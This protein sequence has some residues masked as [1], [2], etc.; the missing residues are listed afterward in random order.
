MSQFGVLSSFDHN[1][2]CWQVYRDRLQQWFIAND[3][4]ETKDATGVKRRAILLSALSESTYLANTLLPCYAHTGNTRFISKTCGFGERYKFS[5]ATQFQ[6]ERMTAHCG[7][8]NVEEALRDHFVMGMLPGAER[9]KLFAQDPKELTLAK[10]VELAESVRSGRL[11]AAQQTAP[12]A[13]QLFKISSANRASDK[14]PC[15]VCGFK[16]HSSA[17]C[18]SANDTC[19][20]CNV[21]GHLRRMCKKI[22]YMENEGIGE[23]G[24]DGECFNIRTFHGE[25]MMLS[26]SVQEVHLRFQIDSGS[27]VTAISSQ[28]YKRYFQHALLSP[29]NKQLLSYN[30]YIITIIRLINNYK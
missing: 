9:E 14:V 30:G 8:L 2:Q 3:V 1:S 5:A 28:T 12:R 16:N 6:G 20:K 24:D 29:C 21:K 11:G 27:A 13:D 22:N 25:P 17:Q 19:K 26:V 4:V 23:I 7:F 10:A 15:S 18:R